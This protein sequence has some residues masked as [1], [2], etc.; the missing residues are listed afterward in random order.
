VK[1]ILVPT[2]GVLYNMTFDV[3]FFDLFSLFRRH[4]KYFLRV[5]DS[6]K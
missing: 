3:R 6:S 5:M 2:A 1:A 4:L